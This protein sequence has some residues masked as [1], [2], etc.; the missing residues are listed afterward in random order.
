MWVTREPL[1]R[2]KAGFM[3][4]LVEQ[5][6]HNVIWSAG[7]HG[8][9]VSTDQY[10]WNGASHV[11]RLLPARCSHWRSHSCVVVHGCDYSAF[12]LYKWWAIVAIQVPLIALMNP[13]EALLYNKSNS[14]SKESRCFIHKT[15]NENVCEWSNLA[16]CRNPGFSFN[17]GN[18]HHL[19]QLLC[20]H[21]FGH[22][23]VNLYIYQPT[24]MK[25][26]VVPMW[27]IQGTQ[28]GI[29]LCMSSTFQLC[30]LS[31]II[32]VHN[33]IHASKYRL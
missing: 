17:L 10:V 18:Q 31:C 26:F 14:S 21:G 24:L 1:L 27:E 4:F 22:A 20:T 13:L 6:L 11:S 28:M 8:G 2:N 29:F 25:A 9:F 33:C 16:Q 7:N 3:L 5:F 12:A 30:P 32:L 19:R 15:A 23:D